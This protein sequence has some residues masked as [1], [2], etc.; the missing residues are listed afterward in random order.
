MSSTDAFFGELSRIGQDPRFR[1]VQGNVRF[2]IRDRDQ[3]R[4]WTLTIDHGRLRVAAGGGPATTV[5][6]LSAEVAEAMVRG[7]INGLAA[8]LR[9][10]IL[11]DG[12]LSLALRMGRLFH[13][14]A[15]ARETGQPRA[16]R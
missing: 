3:V 16:Q 5:L 13:T 6:T 8:M 12:D 10:E 11:V 2:D 1:K 15:A 7:E 9:G 4:Q 14:P